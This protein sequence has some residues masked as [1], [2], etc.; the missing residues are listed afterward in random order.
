MCKQNPSSGKRTWESE[1][2]WLAL[3]RTSPKSNV[4]W[5]GIILAVS[6][7]DSGKGGEGE[8]KAPQ[9]LIHGRSM[10]LSVCHI[11]PAHTPVWP[12]TH[13]KRVARQSRLFKRLR[14]SR[15]VKASAVR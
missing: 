15:L 12:H 13:E 6:Q 5:T 9:S 11:F 4:C 7:G 14:Q 10:S 8:R 2:F 3:A 1:I